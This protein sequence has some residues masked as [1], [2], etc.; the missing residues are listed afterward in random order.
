MEMR[1][2]AGNYVYEQNSAKNVKLS[3]HD[4]AYIEE[5][6]CENFSPI[7]LTDKSLL[8]LLGIKCIYTYDDHY[9]IHELSGFTLDRS[10]QHES[11]DY[12]LEHVHQL[13]NL[14]YALKGEELT[15]NKTT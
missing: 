10:F 15:L 6:K 9:Y 8:K 2:T 11:M 7:P 4:I 14:Y 1:L 3:A 13:Q 12:T 5:H